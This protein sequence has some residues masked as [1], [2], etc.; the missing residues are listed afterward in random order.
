MSNLQKSK[1]ILNYWS[2]GNCGW[3]NFFNR[4]SCD[5]CGLGTRPS[6]LILKGGTK[7]T[8]EQAVEAL[9]HAMTIIEAV[10]TTGIYSRGR[11]AEAWMKKY[12]P[13]W[14]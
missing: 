9:D 14:S 11:D 1:W 7:I 13:N 5:K 6:D 3:S 2:C 12:Y 8:P 10:G 4:E